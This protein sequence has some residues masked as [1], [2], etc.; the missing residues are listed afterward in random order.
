MFAFVYVLLFAVFI[1][2]LTRKIQ[3]GP[4]H[5]EESEAMPDSWK[6]GGAPGEE[7]RV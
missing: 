7:A 2:L 4:D 3:H 5:E 1:F 6:G